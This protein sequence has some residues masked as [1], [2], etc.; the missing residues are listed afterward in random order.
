MEPDTGSVTAETV[1][2][3][4]GQISDSV[5][6]RPVIPLLI[7]FI[8]GIITAF[9]IPGLTKF[10]VTGIA[11]TSTIILF[12]LFLHKNSRL[13][14]LALFF[15]LGYLA[16][17]PWTMT[18]FPAD[19]VRHYVDDHRQWRI[20]G[21]ID[22]EPIKQTYRLV[23]ILNHLRLSQ[24]TDN[25][26]AV[27]VRGK[28]RCSIYKQLPDL[29]AGDR[30][31]FTS[32]IKPFTNFNNPGGFNYKQYMTFKN[33][34]GNAYTSSNK[35]SIIPADSCVKNKLHDM[36]KKI[37]SLI[38]RSS[39]N[40]A[41][42]IIT[43]LIL[44]DRRQISDSLK[45]AFA[46]AGISHIL[47]ISGLHIGIVASGAFIFFK[48]LL[49]FFP[50]VLRHAW[51][52]KGAALLS[53]F[54]VII[55]GILAG[56]SPSTQ[57]A[58]AMVSVFLLTFL[59]ER[60]HDLLNTLAVAA[61]IILIIHPPS[62]FSISFQLSFIAVLFIIYG[63][64]KTAPARNKAFR[65]QSFLFK[66]VYTFIFVSGFAI[67]GTAPLVM[68][69]FNQIPTLGI[70]SNLIFVP[71]IGFL[72]VPVSLFSVLVLFPF[73]PEAAG[74]GLKICGIILNHCLPVLHYISDLS[75][76]TINTVTPSIVE[77]ICIYG[78]LWCFLEL[79]IP[80]SS[81]ANK[82]TEQCDN[83]II[84][85]KLHGTNTEKPAK[86]LKQTDHGISH[87]FQTMTNWMFLNNHGVKT[88]LLILSMVLIADTCYWI[89][90]RLGNDKLKITIIDVG[91]GN[92]ALLEMPHGHC[93]L[94]DG[95]GFTD[96]AIFDVG[97]SIVGPFLLRKKIR[98]IDTVLLTHP[99][100][101][102]L[103]GLIHILKKFHV[104]RVLTT[105]D[106]S[107]CDTYK[108]FIKIIHK[109]N[110]PNPE[111]STMP[112]TITLNGVFLEILNPPDNFNNLRAHDA[113]RNSNNNS[114]VIKASFG[115]QS[116]L[117]PGDIMRAAEKELVLRQKNL[118][119]D[120]LLAPHHGSKTSSTPGFLNY[121][122]P[123]VAIISCGKQNRFGFPAQPVL[124]RYEK[125]PMKIFR[126][127][128]NGAVMIST[129]GH[130]MRITPVF[131]KACT[132]LN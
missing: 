116:I 17:M 81:S 64:S 31:T 88:L 4:S 100:S 89:E 71:L 1:Q 44:G 91:Q 132:L 130:H 6:F 27:E 87:Y 111:F 13:S 86:H 70:L 35:L 68:F 30:I 66:T 72:V 51:T 32:K 75:F 42:Q 109:K 85:S 2:K 14:P 23:C 15:C 82:K 18:A 43:A 3:F 21:T 118:H 106:I 125:Y 11:A 34:W 45:D 16:L 104:K 65:N 93:V 60:D 124:D 74:W 73:L 114:M 123:K 113:W 79:I 26:P 115:E 98:T 121:V 29:S 62:L 92:A 53:I 52:K 12:A 120:I 96:N 55:Y 110:I 99:D 47:A 20:S 83:K 39:S 119:A 97:A 57:R 101:D 56:M 128:L 131:G 54:P 50:P 61:M 78:L 25:E 40:A 28:I 33:I 117:F 76:C 8:S 126:T 77:I 84:L 59:M 102:H 127:D 129:D 105:H 90:K 67:I 5:F 24:K 10:A 112:K 94:I 122:N 9:Y 48:W 37:K 46:R 49:S 22:A 7:A 63:M 69:Y 38:D 58:V 19:H 80:C 108:Q 41:N 36:R 103:N 95:G 107:Q